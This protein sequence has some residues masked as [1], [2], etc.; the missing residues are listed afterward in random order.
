MPGRCSIRP[1]AEP[2]SENLVEKLQGEALQS[3]IHRWFLFKS[4]MISVSRWDAR[5]KRLG[6]CSSDWSRHFDICRKV[7]K[8]SSSQ[9][10]RNRAATYNSLDPRI[11]RRSGHQSGLAHALRREL[12]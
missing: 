6:I 11:F 3:Y 12:M 8:G 1:A 4:A 7:V 5:L 2:T 9:S 10:V